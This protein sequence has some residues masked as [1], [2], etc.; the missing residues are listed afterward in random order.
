MTGPPWVVLPTYNEAENVEPI[1]GAVLDALPGARVLIVDDGSP[2]GTGA[3][4]D[5]WRPRCWCLGCASAA[6]A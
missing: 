1:V 3:I 6:A 2:D 4:A 5:R